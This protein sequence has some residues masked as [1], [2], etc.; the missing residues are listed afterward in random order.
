MINNYTVNKILK[1]EYEYY[2]FKTDLDFYNAVESL[3]SDGYVIKKHIFLAL[4]LKKDKTVVLSP[5][6]VNNPDDYEEELL[7]MLPKHETEMPNF[8]DS[9]LNII[10][11][12]RANY[13]FEGAYDVDKDIFDKKYEH[14]IV[15]LLDG[16][17][18]N[19]LE[20]NMDENSH[21]RIHKFKNV[22]S[23][24]PSTTAAATTSIKTGKTPLQTGWTGWHH[25]FEEI[26]RDVIL[27]NGIDYYTEEK[28]GQSAFKLNPYKPYF[29]DMGIGGIVEPDFSKPKNKLKEVLKRSLKTIRHDK[30][31]YVY[32]SEPDSTMHDVGTYEPEIKRMLE[33]IDKQVYSY[34]KK[35]PENTL[36]IV[37]ADHGHIPVN[38]IKFYDNKIL[39]NMLERRPGNDTRALSFKVKDGMKEEFEKMF[40]FFYSDIYKL[41]PSDEAIKLGYFGDPN[42]EI[43]PFVKGFLGDFVAFGTN[44]YILTTKENDFIFKS[45]HA[46]ISKEEM[47]VP[48]IVF[49]K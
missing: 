8:N 43:S 34:A 5:L 41:Y 7:N 30:T 16:L 17:G 24:F 27:F 10:S 36:L 23:I 29:A 2:E 21:L 20:K 45:H 13:G 31:Q 28:T 11:G 26:K 46:G 39:M 14:T 40:N 37:T 47:F 35:L 6:H 18:V 1:N 48:I 12:F 44:E 22:H 38:S 32:W 4:E 42:G 25:Y 9:V 19:V 3:L 15:L 33:K 49:K